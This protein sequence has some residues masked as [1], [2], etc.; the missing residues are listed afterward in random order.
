MIF[1]KLHGC[2]CG[3]MSGEDGEYVVLTASVDE[4]LSESEEQIIKNWLVIE[5]GLERG[6]IDNHHTPI[7]FN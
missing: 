3:T 1:T 7:I 6:G 2:Y 5:S 4:P